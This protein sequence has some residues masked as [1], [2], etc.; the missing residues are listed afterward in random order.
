MKKVVLTGLAV[1]AVVG[2]SLPVIA[3]GLQREDVP[4]GTVITETELAEPDAVKAERVQN[5]EPEAVRCGYYVDANGDGVCDHCVGSSEASICENYVDG[6]GDGICD[7][8]VGSSEASV[9]GSYVDA[10]GDGVCD[11][12]VGQQNYAQ[13]QES[14]HYGGGHHGGGH[15][16]D[17]HHN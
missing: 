13:P 16:R 8:C 2:I 1:L 17:R 6:N 4:V 9:C 10:N 5:I 11:H 3:S 15:H 12:C 7:H 14:G